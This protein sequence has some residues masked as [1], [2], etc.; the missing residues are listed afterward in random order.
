MNNPFFS[1]AF[2]KFIL[3]GVI[4]TLIG[5]SVMFLLFNLCGCSYWLSSTSNYLIGGIVSFFLNKHFTF[6][7]KEHSWQQVIMFTV[8]LASCYLISYSISRF[9]SDSL[10]KNANP[11]LRGNVALV[12]GAVLYVVLNY[13]GQ[14]HLVFSHNRQLS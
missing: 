10:L 4:N 11:T 7:N 3:V 6:Q 9:L 13:L 2:V 12:G 14:K 5:M 1:I 8:T